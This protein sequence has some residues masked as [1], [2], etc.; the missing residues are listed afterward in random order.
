MQWSRLNSPLATNVLAAVVAWV[1]G[2]VAM[3]LL[4]GGLIV[5]AGLLG[6]ERMSGLVVVIALVASLAILFGGGFVCSRLAASRAGVWILIALLILPGLFPGRGG[7]P[8][9]LSFG[10][11]D[12][13]M[14]GWGGLLIG[15]V[16]L[17]LAILFAWLLTVLPVLAGANYEERR[18]T[19]AR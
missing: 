17:P 18:R 16:T 8:F 12:S 9:G 1:A 7:S 10:G 15:L 14:T 19:A 11:G 6:F 5:L 13:V 3:L 4:G 2:M